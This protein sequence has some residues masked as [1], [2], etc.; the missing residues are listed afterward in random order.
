MNCSTQ[1]TGLQFTEDCFNPL[2]LGHRNFVFLNLTEDFHLIEFCFLKNQWKVELSQHRM[3]EYLLL[4][5][6]YSY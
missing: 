3:S 2:I 5:V 4:E 1:A 6:F